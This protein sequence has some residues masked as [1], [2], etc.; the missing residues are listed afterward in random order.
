MVP[1]F[2]VGQQHNS[3]LPK[4]QHSSPTCDIHPL[5]LRD[6]QVGACCTFFG[7]FQGKPDETILPHTEE[8]NSTETST[9][10]AYSTTT[11]AI[12]ESFDSRDFINSSCKKGYVLNANYEC[13]M[14]F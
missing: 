12:P 5:M 3:T 14:E 10:E 9:T 2:D 11:I 6:Q 4:P 13:V 1:S 7:R 8:G